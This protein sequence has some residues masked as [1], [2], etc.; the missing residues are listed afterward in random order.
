MLALVIGTKDYTHIKPLDN[1]LNDADDVAKMFEEMGCDVMK[2]TDVTAKE[3]LEFPALAQA[4]DAESGVAFTKKNPEQMVTKKIM[5]KCR[6]EL[7][8]K[9]EHY[10]RANTAVIFAF[11]GHGAEYDGKQYL[12]PQDWDDEPRALED[13]AMQL[14][15][16]LRQI[17]AKKPLLTLAFLDCCR[18]HVE[19]QRGG[20]F[21]AAGLSALAG[22]SGSLVMYAA[23]QGQ[24]ASDG[25][26][27]NGAF[28][29]ALLKHFGT[30]GQTLEQM[31]VSV[32][33]EVKA[34]CGQEPESHN[35]LN[36]AGLCLVPR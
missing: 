18:E 9:I 14:Q 10:G 13:E 16:T 20:V 25:A 3:G 21:G 29:E 12:L 1:T 27:R 15:A 19:L 33:N 22:P 8:A 6:R 32:R 26:S 11:M 31:A 24:L 2:L 28:T 7:L 23:G 17:E 30:P 5:E 4:P 34:K 36:V 35:R